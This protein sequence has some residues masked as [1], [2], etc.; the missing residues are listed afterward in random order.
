LAWRRSRP[1]GGG[2]VLV[3]TTVH[4]PDDPR[5]RERTVG[6]LAPVMPVRYA[7][8]APGP[9]HVD[10]FT[11][12]PLEGNRLRRWVRGLRE[13]LRSDVAV[14]SI[15]DPELLPVGF[16]A[17]ATGRRV[18]IDVH[19]DVPAQI[20]R[21]EYLPQALRWPLALF[22]GA[23]IRVA[24]RVC[25]VT[26][27]EHNYQHLVTRPQ[28][29]FVNYPLGERLP[30]APP[31][32]D[33]TPG[34]G[35]AIVYVGDVTAARGAELMVRATAGLEQP[36]PLVLVGRCREPLRS[37]LRALSDELGVDLRLTGFVPHAEAMRHVA[38]ACVGL[39]PLLGD[40]NHRDSL[41]SKVIEYLAV[42][43]PV[44]ASDLPGTR[45]VVEGLPGV[46]LV[47]PGDLAAW[48][49]ALRSA[50]GDQALERAA[51]SGAATVR[52]R[53]TWPTT[54]VIALYRRLRDPDPAGAATQPFTG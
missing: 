50:V 31:P 7:S 29:V 18:V 30:T 44:L 38:A 16:A 2:V 17:R 4:P 49:A 47:P 46:R 19:E 5:V 48:T 45:R 22:A 51:R 12:V 14:V 28:P 52:A 39:S 3:L 9:T 27:A 24:E 8:R 26:L 11:W 41:P 32:P 40:P 25:V 23:L 54:A 53:Y 34:D 10:G 43:V 15:H 20:R 1:H 13:A 37:R 36:R 6:V 35:R 42:G 21:K 33:D